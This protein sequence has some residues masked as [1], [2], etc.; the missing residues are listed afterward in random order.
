MNVE[1]LKTSVITRMFMV[2]YIQTF[3]NK[4]NTFT[5]WDL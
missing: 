4:S 1:N 2:A 5:T 3:D